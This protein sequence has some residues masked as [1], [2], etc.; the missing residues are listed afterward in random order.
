MK[1]WTMFNLVG[2]AGFCLQLAVLAVLLRVGW[3]YLAASA[4]AVETAVLHNF[5]WHERWTWRDRAAHGPARWRRLTRF[6]LLN[7]TVSLAGNLSL[8]WVL[9]GLLHVP[10]I[11]ANAIS[12]ALCALVN[13]AAS[14]RLVFV[15]NSALP[16]RPLRTFHGGATYRGS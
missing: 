6:H 15:R 11:P 4:L 5:V 3:H 2:M 13:F 14:E 7:G 10:P 9:A 1:R 12:V 8:M 16:H